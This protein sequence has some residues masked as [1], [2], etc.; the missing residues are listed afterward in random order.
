M[1]INVSTQDFEQKVLGS[2]KPVL[3]DFWAPWCGPCKMVAP[4]LEALEQDM[5]D[6]LSV[7]KVNVDDNQQLAG[8]FGLRSIPTLMLFDTGA[9]VAQQ[10][11]ALT[12]AQLDGWLNRH[13]NLD[14][15]G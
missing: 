13:M 4:I 9:L 1:V 3:V 5:G 15:A 10:A 14:T 6:Q 7:A 8:R 11:G 2:D 12:R